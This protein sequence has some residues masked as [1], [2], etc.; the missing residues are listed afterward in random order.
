MPCTTQGQSLPDGYVHTPALQQAAGLLRKAVPDREPQR[1]LGCPMLVTPCRSTIYPFPR[2]VITY[3]AEGYPSNSRPWLL[4]LAM[5]LALRMSSMYSPAHTHREELP[6]KL[7]SL[8]PGSTGGTQAL[9]LLV[10]QAAGR[11]G[12]K[13]E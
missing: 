1:T 2:N 6:L 3:R 4:W 12:K 10:V 9:G 8:I 5:I 7:K 13:E 11:S